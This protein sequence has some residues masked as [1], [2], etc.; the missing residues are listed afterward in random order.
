MYIERFCV[1]FP[2]QAPENFD[3]GSL[4]GTLQ[5]WIRDEKIGGTLI[6]VV[7][8]RHV[9]DGPGIMFVTYE[10]NYMVEHQDFYGLYVQRKWG[11]VEDQ[12]HTDAIIDLVTKAAK[13]GSLLEAEAGI[14]LQGNTFH[15]ISNDRLNAPNTDE[16]FEAVKADL[17]EALGKIYG[18]SGFSIERLQNNPKDRLTLVVTVD[19]P[20]A[21]ADLCAVT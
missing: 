13:F 15:Y 2:A 16:A 17:S 8:Y 6:D 19:S 12:P 11:D 10:I 1:K 21:I 5:G 9:P 7:D 14:S 4:I 20:V 18:G 3:E